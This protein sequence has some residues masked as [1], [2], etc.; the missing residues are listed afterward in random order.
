MENVGFYIF[1]L[2]FTFLDILGLLA[3][4][5]IFLEEPTILTWRDGSIRAIRSLPTPLFRQKG[6]FHFFVFWAS[7]EGGSREGWSRGRAGGL[8]GLSRGGVGWNEGV[9]GSGRG[10][11]GRVC[12]RIFSPSTIWIFS[13]VKCILI[14]LQPTSG[15]WQQSILLSRRNGT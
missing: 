6:R 5:L 12:Q 9:P 11:P 15:G 2:F 3:H 1:F 4:Y 13:Q 14:N 10:G 8:E 7:G